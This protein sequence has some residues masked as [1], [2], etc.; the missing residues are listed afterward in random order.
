M[1]LQVIGAGLSRTGTLSLKFALEHLGFGP[2]CHAIEML[3]S[4]REQ[5]PL[6]LQV[7][8]GAPDWDAMFARFSSTVDLP[9]NKYWR[10]LAAHFPDAK[11]IL[12][13]R[14]ADTWL[15]SLHRS[16]LAPTSVE[17][18]GQNPMVAML[19]AAFMDFPVAQTGDRDF[20]IDY[21]H[22]WEAD[23]IAAFPPERLLVYRPGDGWEPLCAFLGVPVPAEP[24]PRINASSETAEAIATADTSSLE[25]IE[26][27]ARSY[28]DTMRGMAFP[29]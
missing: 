23:V 20:M 13:T 11:V 12:S 28:L 19:Q 9:A 5:F 26:A 8:Q 27:S 14:D 6:W 1:P 24:Y 16:I 25:A 22:Q 17:R 4:V 2:C 7:A 10:E 15:E 18:M 3:S 21:F 29:G